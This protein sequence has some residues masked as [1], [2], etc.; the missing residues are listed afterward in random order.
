MTPLV[1][2]ISFNLRTFSV[3]FV[4]F[5]SSLVLPGFLLAADMPETRGYVI[6]MVHTAT[7][8]DEQTCEQALVVCHRGL[9]VFH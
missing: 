6:S 3:S 1:S 2:R 8:V 7:Y 4:G 5:L 9:I